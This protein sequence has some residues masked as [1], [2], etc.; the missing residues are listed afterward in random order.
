VSR[1]WDL[2]SSH[3]QPCPQYEV[4]IAAPE[5]QKPRGYVPVSEQRL[6][7]KPARTWRGRPTGERARRWRRMMDEGGYTSMSALARDEGVSPTAVSKAL[8]R[9]RATSEFQIETG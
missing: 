3:N 5:I 2:S 7:P 9:L 4:E 8:L 6:K 1:F